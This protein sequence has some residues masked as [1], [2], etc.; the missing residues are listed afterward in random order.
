[1]DTSVNDKL[2][3]GFLVAP[4]PMG[5]PNFDHTLVLM[6]LHDDNGSLGFVVNRRSN[7]S[8][9][10]LLKEL[11]IEPHLEDR[12]VLLGGPVSNSTGFVLY[13]HPENAPLAPGMS[14]TPTISLSPSKEVLVAAANNRLSGRFELLLGYAGWGPGQLIGELQR[15]SWLHAEFDPQLLFDVTLENRWADAYRRLGVSPLG[16]VNVP[17]GAF[18]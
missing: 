16:F 9:H 6:A 1:M 8:L 11:E 10:A 17:G 3:P 12:P 13:E 14:V 15:G 7:I 5:D 18:A 4:P 2:A